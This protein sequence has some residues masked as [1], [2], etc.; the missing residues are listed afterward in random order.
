MPGVRYGPDI[1]DDAA[2]MLNDI[3]QFKDASKR[4]G[5]IDSDVRGRYNRAV[6]MAKQLFGLTDADIEKGR[7]K[8]LK[9][10]A[11][12]GNDAR[13]QGARIPGRRNQTYKSQKLARNKR[14]GEIMKRTQMEEFRRRSVAAGDKTPK[15][16]T[17]I[18]PGTGRLPKQ[19]RDVGGQT[20]LGRTNPKVLRDAVARFDRRM[21]RLNRKGGVLSDRGGKRTK[22]RAQGKG[23]KQDID[24]LGIS[25]IKVTDFKA[26]VKKGK[27]PKKV[28]VSTRG[29][30]VSLPKSSTR[31][32]SANKTRKRNVKNAGRRRTGVNRPGR[33]RR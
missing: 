13:G 7:Y 22:I 17:V 18:R 32:K 5:K 1:T 8:D 4:A 15:G 20:L 9:T 30:R 28:N 23:G 33:K 2:Q 24:K 14:T 6:K 26:K 10:L 29:T 19:V 25:K 16:R 11:R 3:L 27:P 12:Y 31:A 21:A